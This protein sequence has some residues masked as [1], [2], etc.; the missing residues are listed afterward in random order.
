MHQHEKYIEGGQD[1]KRHMLLAKMVTEEI[2]KEL[3]Q[4]L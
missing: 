4:E 1:S 3:I 2:D